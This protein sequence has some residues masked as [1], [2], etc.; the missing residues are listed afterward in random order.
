MQTHCSGINIADAEPF[1]TP[2]L[3]PKHT[4]R[5]GIGRTW[6]TEYTRSANES[7]ASD[8]D[9]LLRLGFVI[10]RSAVQVRA[11][12]PHFLTESKDRDPIRVAIWLG[13]T[14]GRQ[15]YSG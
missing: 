10:S 9:G 6:W 12:A 1:P 4:A 2:T 5:P 11:P 15:R 14:P 8:T 13:V 3:T 7:D